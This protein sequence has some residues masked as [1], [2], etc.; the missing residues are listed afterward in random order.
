M[1]VVQGDGATA[2][3]KIGSSFEGRLVGRGP[4]LSGRPLGTCWLTRR[5]FRKPIRRQDCSTRSSHP[6]H[7]GRPSNR[8]GPG[9]RAGPQGRAAE[10]AEGMGR[11][12]YGL[13]RPSGGSAAAT[14]WA[15]SASVPHHQGPGRDVSQRARMSCPCVPARRWTRR[16]PRAGLGPGAAAPG[17]E[18][19]PGAN[20]GAIARPSRFAAPPW[21]ARLPPRDQVFAALE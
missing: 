15:A 6:S 17:T 16:G 14:T 12:P 18:R 19:S 2:H 20:P 10:R 21:A 4:F 8:R 13:R 3:C 7:R 1:C 11:S 5:E 9:V